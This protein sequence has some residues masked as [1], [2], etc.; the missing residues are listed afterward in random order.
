MGTSQET[1]CWSGSLKGKTTCMGSDVSVEISRPGGLA[2][3]LAGTFQETGRSP[4]LSLESRLEHLTA[5]RPVLT[6]LAGLQ[7]EPKDALLVLESGIEDWAVPGAAADALRHFRLK[8][9]W[10]TRCALGK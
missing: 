4:R 6:A 7:L 3:A 9:S 2:V 10:S 5:G 8:V 1:R